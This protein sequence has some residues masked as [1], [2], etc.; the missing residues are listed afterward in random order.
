MTQNLVPGQNCPLPSGELTVKISA[1]GNADFSAFRLY[2][3]G[4]TAH[5]EDFVFYGQTR[6]ADG[7]VSLEH[8]PSSAVF[9]I[10]LSRLNKDI[11]KIAFCATSDLPTI[12]GLGR[13]ELSI[14]SPSGAVARCESALSGRSE[15]A[16]IMGEIY[17]RGDQWK[18]RFVDQ[19]FNGGLKPLA[20]FFGVDISDDAPPPPPEKKI[21]LSKITLTKSKPRVDLEKKNMKGGV[22]K[23]N[24][25]WH[26]GEKKGGLARLFGGGGGDIDLDLG[27]YVRAKDGRQTIVQALGDTFGSLDAFPHVRLTGD[28]RTGD[29]AEGEW[30]Y[31]NGDKLD[32]LEEIVVY[33][34]I[35]DGAPN[36]S[37]TDGRVKIFIEGQP[38]IETFLTGTDNSLPMCAI[39]RITNERGVLSVER[40]DRYFSGHKDMDKAFGWGFRWSP[41]RK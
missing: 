39:A 19:G 2:A 23:V 25:N 29:Q 11:E 5:D 34:F 31:I 6:I 33:T 13:L 7:S 21:N 32:Q 28:D 30:I 20:E 3:N 8:T 24:L 38:E 1:G 18:F 10:H 26:R 14:D 9:R 36:W 15:A 22:F 41:G 40:L 27:A 12:A 4:K 35:Y 17:R 16:L 37:A